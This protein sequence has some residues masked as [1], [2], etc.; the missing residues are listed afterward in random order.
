MITLKQVN[1]FIKQQKIGIFIETEEDLY[2]SINRDKYEWILTYGFVDLNSSNKLKVINKKSLYQGLDKYIK[3]IKQLIIY[4]VPF[5]ASIEFP[6][7]NRVDILLKKEKTEYSL[8]NLLQ[9]IEE[10]MIKFKI[11]EI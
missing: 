5:L 9:D 7:L 11:K 2:I 1:N 3:R 8:D 10:L 6:E 4:R